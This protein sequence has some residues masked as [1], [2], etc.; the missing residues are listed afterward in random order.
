MIGGCGRRNTAWTNH[1][2]SRRIE[3]KRRT[4]SPMKAVSLSSALKRVGRKV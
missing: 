2:S 1:G 3:M 4:A